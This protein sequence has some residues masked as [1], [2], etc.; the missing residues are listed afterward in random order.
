LQCSLVESSELNCEFVVVVVRS[1]AEYSGLDKSH[2]VSLDDSE[3]TFVDILEINEG[4]SANKLY[5]EI[6]T[7]RSDII[8][9]Q[10]HWIHSWEKRE[11]ED[12]MDIFDFKSHIKCFEDNIIMDF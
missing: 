4:F 3:Q 1:L 5:L 7:R 6:L 2:A 8:F 10:E 9:M 11:I 12:F